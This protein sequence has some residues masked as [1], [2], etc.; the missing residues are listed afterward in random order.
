MDYASKNI[1]KEGFPKMT[2]YRLSFCQIQ[3]QEKIDSGHA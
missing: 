1:Q 3:L 2:S